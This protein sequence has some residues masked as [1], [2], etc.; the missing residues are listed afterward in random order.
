MI[1]LNRGKL[2]SICISFFAPARND[3]L[4]DAYAM[5]VIARGYLDGLDDDLEVLAQKKQCSYLSFNFL[6]PSGI[7][8][9]HSACCLIGHSV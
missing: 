5:A 7:L 4:P 6:W 2:I 1:G 8:M 9:L 3:I